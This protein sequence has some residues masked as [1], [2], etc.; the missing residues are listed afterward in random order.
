[1]TLW[2]KHLKSFCFRTRFDTHL[3]DVQIATAS[4]VMPSFGYFSS[5]SF[6]SSTTID[7][8]LQSEWFWATSIASFMERLLDFRS[9]WIVFIHVVRGR[10]GGLLQFSKWTAVNPLTPTVAIWAQ[11]WSIL[12]QTMLS[13]HWSCISRKLWWEVH[14]RLFEL[15]CNRQTDRQRNSVLH[16]VVVLCI[17]L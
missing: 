14:W 12:C 17:V 11:L 10:P 16:S 6:L 13:C 9:C 15:S 4:T 1:M 7:I 2:E 5:S 3:R 8:S